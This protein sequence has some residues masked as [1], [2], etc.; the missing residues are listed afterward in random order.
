MENLVKKWKQLVKTSSRDEALTNDMPINESTSIDHIR[1]TQLSI[2]SIKVTASDSIDIDL[3]STKS[4][5]SELTGSPD[6][7]NVVSY[8][9]SQSS[10]K[11][12]TNNKSA[13]S[14]YTSQVNIVLTKE[15]NSNKNETP[16]EIVSVKSVSNHE[17]IKSIASKSVD[18]IDLKIANNQEVAKSEETFEVVEIAEILDNDAE[19]AEILKII[20]KHSAS[21]EFDK[22]LPVENGVKIVTLTEE[23]GTTAPNTVDSTAIMNESDL[24]EAEN[25]EII[26]NNL[27][28]WLLWIKHTIESQVWSSLRIFKKKL[29]SILFLFC[30]MY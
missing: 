25:C 1:P 26:Y 14:S 10:S 8:Q 18:S 9:I 6:S 7:S 28:D 16:K 30:Q 5:S 23:N 15:G 27:F 4:S 11:I 17:D 20:Q 24:S 22:L 13:S 19:N 12:F 2:Q 21:V 29:L 3:K